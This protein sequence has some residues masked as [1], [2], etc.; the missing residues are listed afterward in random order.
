MI[1]TPSS[2]YTS[3][4]FSC[5]VVFAF[6]QFLGHLAIKQKRQLYFLQLFCLFVVLRLLLPVEIP[7]SISIRSHNG[8]QFFTDL[9][10]LQLYHHT[11]FDWLLFV[12]GVG[13]GIQLMRYLFD[14]YKGRKLLQ[15][16]KRDGILEFYQNHPVYFTDEVS[17][18]MVLF[19]SNVLIPISFR[20]SSEYSSIVQHEF[21]HIQNRDFLKKQLVNALLI[22]YWWFYPIYLLQKQIN[23][24]IELHVDSQVTRDFSPVEYLTYA[25]NLIQV[26]KKVFMLEKSLSSLATPFVTETPAMLSHRVHFLLDEKSKKRCWGIGVCLLCLGILGTIVVEPYGPYQPLNQEQKRIQTDSYILEKD[27]KQYLISDGINL[28]YVDANTFLTDDLKNL[29]KI[30]W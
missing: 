30:N 13:S 3:L 14:I 21:Q 20:G 26:Q 16:I 10:N 17:V 1:L 11:L 9:F 22:V 27:G 5:F 18:P 6:H 12:W 24:C 25:N 8:I 7:M 2:V 29:P 19:F 4:I 23:L 15:S 28:G